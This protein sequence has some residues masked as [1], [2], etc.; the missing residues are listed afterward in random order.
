[1]VGVEP[2][3]SEGGVVFFGPERS[4]EVQAVIDMAIEVALPATEL[5]YLNYAYYAQ[6][7]VEQNNLTMEQA[8]AETESKIQENLQL[9]EE[10][11][12]TAVVAVPT[13]IPTPILAQGEIALQFGLQTY[14]AVSSTQERWQAI[15][16]EFVANDPE[17]GQ[18]VLRSENMT[19][20]QMTEKLDCMVLPYNPIAFDDVQNYLPLD[21]LLNS[22]PNFNRDD[23]VPGVLAA[24]EKEGMTYGLPLAAQTLVIFYNQQLL[25][26]AGAGIPYN[27]WTV[28]EFIDTLQVL[29]DANSSA[30]PFMPNYG[31][32]YL[33]MLMAAYGGS[34]VDYS[35][36]PPTYNLTDP[37]VQEAIR[38]VL[39]LAKDGLIDYQELATGSF[40][41]G[42]GGM[43]ALSEGILNRDDWRFQNVNENGEVIERPVMYPQGTAGT[44]ISVDVIAGYISANTQYPEACYRWLSTIATTPELLPAMPARLSMLEDPALTAAHGETMVTLYTEFATLMQSPEAI[45]FS[46]FGGATGYEGYIT[47]VFMGR[48]F[49][50]YVLKDADLAAELERANASIAEFN[51]CAAGIP[52]EENLGS[53]GQEELIAYFEQFQDCAITADPE[54]ESA[55][56]DFQ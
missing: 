31:N 48:A 27:G 52:K 38:Q 11:R 33:L 36:T 34:P 16:D 20:Q 6:Q 17:V 50:N 45:L 3:E 32:R 40:G 18:I 19:S 43:I 28:S 10:Q 54:I 23:L 53:L 12:T 8:L 55:F 37:A 56:P 14:Y 9:A 13:P 42:F 4:P 39:D 51:E 49:D 1:L 5:R 22:D 15:A 26:E 24:V 47:E 25:E 41:G 2:P 46:G 29:K 44:P 21:P 35:T 30:K 7:Q